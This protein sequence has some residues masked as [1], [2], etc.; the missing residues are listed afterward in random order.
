M[1]KMLL[2]N[3]KINS[4]IKTGHISAMADIYKQKSL[5]GKT[6][7]MMMMMMMMKQSS[8]THQLINGFLS[9]PGNSDKS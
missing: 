4:N 3:S 2:L 1:K 9:V 7:E 5:K 6:A 8:E